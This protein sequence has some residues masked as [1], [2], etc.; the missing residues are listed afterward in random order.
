M[1]TKIIKN[2]KSYLPCE[3]E[4]LPEQVST[5]NQL[6]HFAKLNGFQVDEEYED[7]FIEA[8]NQK[9]DLNNSTY[10]RVLN[11]AFSEG[12]NLITFSRFR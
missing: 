3:W 8:V 1:I 9:L 12:K 11:E 4:P 10:K 7:I 2:F 6:L 5:L